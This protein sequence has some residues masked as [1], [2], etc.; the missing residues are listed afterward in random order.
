MP[1]RLVALDL[2]GTL[3][4]EDGSVD[5]RD[6]AA[7]G[8][9]LRLGVAITLATGRLATG[10]LP[11]ARALGIAAPLVCADGGL[12]ACG[13]TGMALESCP[14]APAV[15]NASLQAMDQHGLA[16]FVFLGGEIHGERS[17]GE[18]HTLVRTWTE[19]IVLHD[20]L[21]AGCW[22]S[23]PVALVIGVGPRD[24]VDAA[25]RGLQT[26]HVGMAEIAS[27]A[28][29]GEGW[30]LR[31]RPGGCDKGRLLERLARRMGVA[32]EEVCALGDWYNDVPM[33]AWAG[34]AF[35]MADSPEQVLAA[36]GQAVRSRRG[37]GGGVAEA[38][39]RWLGT[40]REIA[41]LFTVDR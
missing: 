19:Q 33:L 27:F 11:T 7:V 20:R 15:A 4:R 28:L 39:R 32:R 29:R 13:R 3:L 18:L 8:R 22:G 23:E 21:T 10:A 5:S 37:E 31:V 2:D 14:L 40:E 36:A 1:P 25:A 30:A 12:L 35:A 9:A 41:S 17:C 16:P 6:A 38:L 26:G 24:L 34:R